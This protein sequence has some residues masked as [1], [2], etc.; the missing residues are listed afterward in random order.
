VKRWNFARAN[1]TSFG[2]GLK[3]DSNRYF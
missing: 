1:Q 3:V 2:S